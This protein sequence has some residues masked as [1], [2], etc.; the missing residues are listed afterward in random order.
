MWNSY[1]LKVK[2][3]ITG[4]IITSSSFL[5][6]SLL[7]YI[8]NERMEFPY[9]I[10]YFFI[11]YQVLS[12]I[13]L[14][15]IKYKVSNNFLF[16]ES[17]FFTSKIDIN[18]I[19]EIKFREITKKYLLIKDRKFTRKNEVEIFYGFNSSIIFTPENI[20]DFIDK[21]KLINPNIK[22]SISEV[23]DTNSK[24]KRDVFYSLI[25]CLLVSIFFI[26]LT[27]KYFNDEKNLITENGKISYSY[28]ST[29]LIHTKFGSYSKKCVNIE[30]EN[31]RNI[32]K[33]TK[34]T[35]LW[36]TVLD[37]NNYLKP[38]QIKYFFWNKNKDIIFNPSIISINN[39]VIKPY[40][41]DI[42]FKIL[43]IISYLILMFILFFDLIQKVI[44]IN[45]FKKVN[46][47]ENKLN[48]LL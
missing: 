39:K 40:N 23:T 13:Y 41:N 44:R 21:I 46:F 3:N 25:S 19:S 42:K 33:L 12:T 36:N 37:S 45:N 7:F 17:I 27:M 43:F 18:K 22:S 5:L 16:K 26:V 10:L 6:Y 30:I 14:I 20:Q 31:S 35:V 1:K 9:F 8:D 24:L 38:I 29:Y 47:E 2:N 4:S 11:F 34:D 28:Y 48:T 32:I 15:T